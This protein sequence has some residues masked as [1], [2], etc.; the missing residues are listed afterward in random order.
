MSA[1]IITA[2][3]ALIPWAVG[4]ALLWLGRIAIGRWIYTLGFAL[5]G[6]HVLCAFHFA[7]SWSHRVAYQHT[8]EQSAA[9]TGMRAGWGL[10]LNYLFGIAWLVDLGRWWR[11]GDLR[12][13]ADRSGLKIAIRVFTLFIFING[14]VVFVPWPRRGLGI[15]LLVLL[16]V[17]GSRL[18]RPSD[19]ARNSAP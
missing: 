10:W 3:A 8:A 13:P 5:F 9:L 19:R 2:W 15:A 17:T 4:L 7:H 14:A 12:Y 1:V 11:L 18:L 6:I 16:I